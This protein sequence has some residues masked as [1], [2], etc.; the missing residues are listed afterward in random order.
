MEY[1]IYHSKDL[2][3]KSSGAIFYNN[4]KMYGEKAVLF[5]YDYGQKLDTRLFKGKSTV[6]VDVSME[7]DRMELLG[8]SCLEFIWIDHHVSAFE[9]LDRYCMKNDYKITTRKINDLIT[10][11]SVPEMNMTYYYSNVLS[12]CEISAK[13][14]SGNLTNKGIELISILGQ[15]DTWRNTEEKKL[16]ND[17]NWASVVIP[18]QFALRSLST[19]EDIAK[20]LNEISKGNESIDNL[21]KCG[22]MCFNYQKNK[23]YDDC[24]N[25]CGGYIFENLKVIALNTTNN[26][27]QSFDG[28]YFKELH[29]AMMAY[30]FNAKKNMWDIS[31]YTTSE[32]V[33]ILSIAEKY[34]GGGHKMA[35]GFSVPFG[36]LIIERDLIKISEPLIL[37]VRKI[38]KSFNCDELSGIMLMEKIYYTINKIEEDKIEKDIIIKGTKQVQD[39]KE[40]W[41]YIPNIMLTAFNNYALELSINYTVEKQ[42]EFDSKFSKYANENFEKNKP[43]KHWQI[44]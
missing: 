41:Y 26:S 19:V 33:D 29:Q 37:D 5:P 21:I 15:Y 1:I 17:K 35:C 36:N 25:K 6:M 44:K 7:M 27:S 23:S 9:K 4:Q 43:S 40:I 32:D 30:S 20:L 3:G 14:F 12:S 18:I 31:L 24:N 22:E 16:F 39:H 2:D 38:P 42:R 28:F 8:N 34:N 10:S 11:Y 13:L